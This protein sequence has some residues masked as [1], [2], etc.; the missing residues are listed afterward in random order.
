MVYDLWYYY[1]KDFKAWASSHVVFQFFISY[2]TISY[3]M[4]SKVYYKIASESR[5]LE[6]QW[7][8]GFT[9]WDR[10]M[11]LYP[12]CCCWCC[13]LAKHIIQINVWLKFSC[14]SSLLLRTLS[15]HTQG[16]YTICVFQI[17]VLMK[18]DDLPHNA[19]ICPAHAPATMSCLNI[20][21]LHAG[22]K[23][24]CPA[25]LWMN[26]DFSHLYLCGLVYIF[27]T[28][29]PACSELA[30][31]TY[32]STLSLNNPYFLPQPSL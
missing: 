10:F 3:V 11:I 16:M 2:F 7:A 20:W 27:F 30:R 21:Y 8:V 15:H 18:L 14:F 22:S 4:K 25:R 9:S 28:S 19:M 5:F 13:S 17:H 1:I 6:Y 26:P 23:S 12:L 24:P 29:R 32:S 31:P